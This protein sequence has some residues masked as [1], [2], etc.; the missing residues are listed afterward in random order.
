MWKYVVY[1]GI[2]FLLPSQLELTK[3]CLS[4]ICD[5]YD[6]QISQPI[7]MNIIT[8][9]V[10]YIHCKW[11]FVGSLFISGSDFYVVTMYIL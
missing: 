7:H 9:D 2:C 8:W 1:V 6:Y 3:K 5:E 11:W 10:V 4:T